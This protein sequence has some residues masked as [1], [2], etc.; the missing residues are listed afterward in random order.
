MVLTGLLLGVAFGFVLQRGR[1]CVT[2]AFRD[3]YLSGS[4]R[5]LTAFFVVIA[6]QAAGVF[7]LQSAGV[8]T[9]PTKD[10]AL[11]AVIV[12]SLLFGVGIVLAGGCATGTY[13]RA[14]EGL[15]G[16][17]MALGM[18]ALF[19]AVMKNGALSPVNSTLRGQTVEAQTLHGT[20]GISPWWLVAALGLGVGYAAWRH[21]SAPTK[22][23]VATL[24]PQHT[25]LRHL[26]F[27]KAWH[28]F[29]TA[30]VIAVIAIVAYPLSF[31]TGR[32]S[33][34]GIT[35]PS[36][37]LVGFLVTG[38]GS[39]AWNWGVMLVLGI[40]LG[41]Y[42]AARGA[43]EFKIRVPDARTS[44]RSL[45]G[46]ALMG[47]GA[48]WAGGCTIGNSMVQTAQ[49]SYQGWVALLFTFIGVGLAT[50]LFVTTHRRAGALSST[51]APVAV[52][53]RG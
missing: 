2:G 31:A 37:D 25:G 43:G 30:L 11:T 36:A 32:E 23:A 12:G 34:L 35:T 13:Y 18:Y 10:V 42:L 52:G 20:L 8:L 3:V 9:L 45:G 47:V 1:F 15:V 46:G 22:T 41:S 27:E 38:D 50:R 29:A 5:W 48:S 21:L 44:V 7:A 16:S 4:T 28:P 39:L 33:G 40:L 49:F 17:W 19:A 53:A 6:V 26:L 24:P 14:G 51:S